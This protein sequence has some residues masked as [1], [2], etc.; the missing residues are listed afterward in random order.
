[1]SWAFSKKTDNITLQLNC[2]GGRFYEKLAVPLSSE[3]T[4]VGRLVES[5]DHQ[6]IAAEVIEAGPGGQPQRAQSILTFTF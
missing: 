1:M 6:P 5:M 4:I 2:V 3:L